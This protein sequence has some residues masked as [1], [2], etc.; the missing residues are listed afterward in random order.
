MIN[1]KF[2]EIKKRKNLVQVFSKKEIF[3][4][5]DLNKINELLK[6]SGDIKFYKEFLIKK[7]EK[8]FEIDL[9]DDKNSYIKFLNI[10]ENTDVF[11]FSEILNKVISILIVKDDLD[12]IKNDYSKFFDV[13][14]EYKIFVDEINITIP[15]EGE[16]FSSIE[17]L[18]LKSDLIIILYEKNSHEKIKKYLKDFGTIIKFEDIYVV[19]RYNKKLI[20]VSLEDFE[21]KKD[22]VLKEVF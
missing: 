4:S 3:V 12:F 7:K 20:F 17:D 18:I 10:I 15:E 2:L 13:F 9:K 14:N 1:D 8:F 11:K 16:I 21:S 22:K 5:I 6:N 19:K